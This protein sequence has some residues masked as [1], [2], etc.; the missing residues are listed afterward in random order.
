MKLIR[1]HFCYCALLL[2]V[3]CARTPPPSGAEPRQPQALAPVEAET[4][5]P[6][7]EPTESTEPTELAEPTEATTS[8]VDHLVG[9]GDP[10]APPDTVPRL[11]TSEPVVGGMDKDVI[12]RVVRSHINEIRDCYNLGLAKDPTLAGRIAIEFTIGPSG[13][14]EQA[15][16]TDLDGLADPAV[17]A[18]IV[19]AIE[20]WVFP[21]PR[22]GGR[23]T[24]SYPFNLE[25]G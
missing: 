10:I 7:I 4:S 13:A 14:V 20:T 23:V 3:G 21:E 16:A 6:P 5:A 9:T 15:K 24:V 1:W 12:R 18:C 11:T 25:P 19:A 22:G 17:P 8:A 2:S